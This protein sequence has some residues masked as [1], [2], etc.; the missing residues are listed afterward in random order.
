[1]GI[2]KQLGDY[3]CDWY[4]IDDSIEY[5]IEY[6]NPE[7]L[8]VPGRIDLVVKLKYIEYK[9]QQQD[10]TF[11]KELYKSH[12]EAFTKGLFKEAGS[13]SKHSIE[14]YFET[15]DLLIDKIS[16]NG[17][18]SKISVIP[19]GQDNQIMDGSH[20]VAIAKYFN[21]KVPIIRF[22]DLRADNDIKF[23]QSRLLNKEYIDYIA[24]EFAKLKDNIFIAISWP[25]A[26]GQSEETESIIKK[27]AHIIYRKD[28]KLSYNGLRNFIIQTYCEHDWLGSAEQHFSGATPQIEGCYDKSGTMNVYLLE[29]ESIENI[30]KIKEEVRALY[31]IG[32]YSMH[33]TDTKEETL[34]L[35]HILFNG[36]SVSFL[37]NGKPDFYIQL[38]KAL[39][40]YKQKIIHNNFCLDDFIVDS[41]TVMGLYGI[42][43]VN[44]I[45]YLSNEINANAI[46]TKMIQNHEDY[47]RY[48]SCDKSELINN[49][50]KHFY[51]NDM[52]FIT[53]S[54]LK[55]FKEKR[56]ERKD[57]IDSKMISSII[58]N[59]KGFKYY[60][61]KFSGQTQRVIRNILFAVRTVLV[62]LTKLVG[63]YDIMKKQYHKM[64]DKK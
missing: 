35:A 56:G 54:V 41:S 9:E 19:V 55:E 8:F 27:R 1:M 57:L 7:E 36:N 21:H 10:M 42:R 60:F 45:D 31:N 22:P 59:E 13:D 26:I 2:R 29:S 4:E 47:L 52:K 16:Q 3:F 23:F 5:K 53:L 33:S 14:K 20:R 12:I 64:L 18:D 61:V 51:Y 39:E 37:N 11:I 28:I 25:R 24:C 40:D 46:D 34:K 17:I 32:N 6:I 30:L 63:L 48:H 62:N 49:P 58:N 50:E 15:F 44:D 38:N 43:K